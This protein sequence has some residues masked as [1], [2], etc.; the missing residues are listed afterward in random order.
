MKK[1]LIKILLLLFMTTIGCA[2]CILKKD[3]YVD[4]EENITEVISAT[5]EIS[6]MSETIEISDIQDGKHS[7]QMVS[8]I[9]VEEQGFG[10]ASVNVSKFRR[11]AVLTTE[12]GQIVAYF[13]EDS[14]PC[15]KLIGE[16]EYCIEIISDME[17]R[18]LGDGHCSRNIGIYNDV[19]WY[20]FGCHANYG[21]YG[22]ISMEEFCLVEEVT[23]T[24]I[25][26]DKKI[27]YPQFYCE[28]DKFL[29]M[30]RNDQWDIGHILI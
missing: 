5:P 29:F 26:M 3:D 23:A 12:Y 28:T 1:S 7:L 11:N 20:A 2:A 27:S 4:D 24:A 21:Y 17:E 15:I 13:R 6:E 22:I 18:L 30:C 8:K 9:C 25:P 10:T 16:Q 14:V 19:L